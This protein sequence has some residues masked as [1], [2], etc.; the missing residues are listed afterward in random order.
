ML[1]PSKK[2]GEH[3]SN[4]GIKPDDTIMIHGDAGISAQYIYEDDKDP[5]EGFFGELKSYL[6]NGTILVPSFTYSATKGE[7]FDVSNTPS[8][9]GLFSEKFRLLDGVQRSQHPIFSVCAFGKHAEDFTISRLDDCFG[10]G[11]F[12]DQ[13]YNSNAKIVTMGCAF[14]RATFVHYVEQRINVSYRYFKKFNAKIMH[15]GTATQLD[16]RYF[17]R[18]LEVNTTL[19]FNRLEQEALKQSFMKRELF[20]RF[21]ARAILARDFFNIARSLILKDEYSLIKENSLI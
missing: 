5:I 7:T 4:L 15:S 19:D 9:V 21:V 2:I 14:E 17:V 8:E 12:F 6:S 20:G 16:V 1:Y 3:L 13:L 10:E 18:N 11:T